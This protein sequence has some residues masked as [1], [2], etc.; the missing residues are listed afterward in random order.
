MGWWRPV[1]M[2]SELK[3]APNACYLGF[4]VVVCWLQ[5]YVGGIFMFAS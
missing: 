5:V 2:S 3:T 4:S 1:Q